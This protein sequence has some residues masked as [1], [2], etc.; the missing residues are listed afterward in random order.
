MSENPSTGTLTDEVK[1]RDR[2]FTQAA[3]EVDTETFESMTSEDYIFISSM[4]QIM[5]KKSHLASLTSGDI[6]YKSLISE[7]V[8]VRT[9]GDTAILT[10]RIIGEGTNAG[11]S[12]SGTHL[13]TRVFVKR[14]GRWMIVSAQATR[15]A[16]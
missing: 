3:I 12:I 7:D 10:A 16:Q 8:K 5:D 4:G 6:D 15:T 2:Q 11:R 1:S 14:G 13:I 9:Y